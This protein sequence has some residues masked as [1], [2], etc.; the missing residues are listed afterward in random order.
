LEFEKEI[1][2]DMGRWTVYGYRQDI[3]KPHRLWTIASSRTLLLKHKLL[4][5]EDMFAGLAQY[6]DEDY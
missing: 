6:E 5:P 1:V 4:H 2:G 3:T